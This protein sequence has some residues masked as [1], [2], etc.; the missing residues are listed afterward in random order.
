[1]LELDP[2]YTDAKLVV[3]AHNY[4]MGSLSFAVKMA[5]A[6]AGLSGDKDK[7]LQYLSDDYHSNGETSVDA[8]VVLMVFLRREHRF[9]EA[10]QIAGAISPRF[11]RNYLFP[12]EEANLLR[13]AEKNSGAEEQYRGCGRTGARAGTAISITKSPRWGSGPAAGREEISG[14]RR[15]L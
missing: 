11:P 10:L 2:H 14:G 4:V 8:G 6:L 9:G 5:V 1:M 7:G 15:S 13:A 12:L 3:G